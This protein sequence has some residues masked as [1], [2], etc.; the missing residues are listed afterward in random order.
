MAAGTDGRGS[1]TSAN[2]VGANIDPSSGFPTG[3]YTLQNVQFN[4]TCLWVGGLTDT[5][6]FT[7]IQA[8]CD[9]FYIV[10]L[11][12][13]VA[14][15]SVSTVVAT[16]T[17]VGI[18]DYQMV[19]IYQWC[20]ITDQYNNNNVRLMPP[21]AIAGGA[22]ASLNPEVAPFNTNIQAIIG[23]E[24][25]NPYTGN[26][27]FSYSEMNSL[28]QAGICF[29]AIIPAGGWG[30]RND[31]NSVGNNQD[32]SVIEYS[33]LTN[34]LVASSAQI[35]GPFLGKNQGSGP[36]DTWRSNVSSSLNNFYGGLGPRI[37]SFT[38]LCNA[39]NNPSS[40]VAQHVGIVQQVVRYKAS[41]LKILDQIQGGT[42]VIT[43][44]NS[45][46]A[47]VSQTGALL[48]G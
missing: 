10:G 3:I 37:D 21:L 39:N 36:N 2:L 48:N 25:N 41:V 35:L 42:S 1:I 13:F 32:Q 15:A 23:T 45:L 31:Y 34:Y 28:G 29:F 4:P 18:V 30:F 17:S 27:P 33:R 5:T 22:I 26:Y 7:Q 38:V 8:F 43:T 47:T 9:K 44:T 6:V 11:L 16:K 19:Y 46:G 12:T 40:S 24:R 20:W 14:G